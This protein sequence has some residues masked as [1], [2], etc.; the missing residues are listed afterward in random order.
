M[1]IREKELKWQTK[2]KAKIKIRTKRR[3]RKIRRRPSN[4]PFRSTVNCTGV[5]NDGGAFFVFRI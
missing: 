4:F 1:L 5:E 3:K 2:N